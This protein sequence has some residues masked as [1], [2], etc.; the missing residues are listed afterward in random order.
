V[1]SVVKHVSFE[2]ASRPADAGRGGARVPH[3]SPLA[4]ACLELREGAFDLPRLR[5]DRIRF[6]FWSRR[7]KLFFRRVQ[8]RLSPGPHLP[9]ERGGMLTCSTPIGGEHGHPL[10]G[11]RRVAAS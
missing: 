4:A 2:R 7:R 1:I 10:P 6:P 3:L 8:L 9:Q 5:R 11:R